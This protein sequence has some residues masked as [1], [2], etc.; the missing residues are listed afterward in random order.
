MSIFLRSST[1]ARAAYSTRS[2]VSPLRV[3][4]AQV[5]VEGWVGEVRLRAELAFVISTSLRIFGSAD[6]RGSRMLEGLLVV[7]VLLVCHHVFFVDFA[8]IVWRSRS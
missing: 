3:L 6:A 8:I 2:T 7:I 4:V 5:R 1:L